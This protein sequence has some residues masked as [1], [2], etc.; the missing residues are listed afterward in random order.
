MFALVQGGVLYTGGVTSLGVIP[1]KKTMYSSTI[2]QIKVDPEIAPDGLTVYG[3]TPH[4][5]A[6]GKK[7]W[8]EKLARTPE[9]KDDLLQR[10]NY[11]EKVCLTLELNQSSVS[12]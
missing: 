7:L 12:I 3:F 5:H 11:L 4:M 8:V 9:H 2:V 6:L 1:P 10:F